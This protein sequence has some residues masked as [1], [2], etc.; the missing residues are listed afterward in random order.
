MKEKGK[1]EVES[2]FTFRAKRDS[3]TSGWE[4][5]QIPIKLIN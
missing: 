3:P 2:F 4:L 5:E 1:R